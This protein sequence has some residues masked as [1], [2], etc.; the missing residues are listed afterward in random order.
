MTKDDL[1]SMFDGRNPVFAISAILWFIKSLVFPSYEY[2]SRWFRP[3]FW[4]EMA[5]ALSPFSGPK[6]LIALTTDLVLSLT[7]STLIGLV[8][9]VLIGL[10]VLFCLDQQFS[11]VSSLRIPPWWVGALVC[12]EVA[13]VLFR[14]SGL[15]ELIVYITGWE[16]FYFLWVI[17]LCFVAKMATDT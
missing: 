5:V 15:K 9:I 12:L 3:L 4:L 1:T 17:I 7:T 14:F 8:V 10:V 13:V 11:F 16:W 2:G 6:E